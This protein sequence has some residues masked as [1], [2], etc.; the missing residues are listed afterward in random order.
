V[1]IFGLHRSSAIFQQLSPDW[2]LYALHSA[3]ACRTPL[4]GRASVVGHSAKRVRAAAPAA[5]RW[6]LMFGQKEIKKE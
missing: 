2:I 5:A 3:R 1:L 4:P 6:V